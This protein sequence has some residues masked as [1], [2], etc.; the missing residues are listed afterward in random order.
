MNVPIAFCISTLENTFLFSFCSAGKLAYVSYDKCASM[1]NH[2]DGDRVFFCLIVF[3]LNV[4]EQTGERIRV[5]GRARRKRRE[6][7][8]GG[9]SLTIAVSFAAH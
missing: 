9:D 4:Q 8:G 1:R 3:K 2:R 5:E 7:A 6:A